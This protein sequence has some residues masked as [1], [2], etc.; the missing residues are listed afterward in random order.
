MKQASVFLNIIVIFILGVYLFTGCSMGRSISLQT[1]L[2]PIVLAD[3]NIKPGAQKVTPPS[4]PKNA[5]EPTP[6]GHTGWVRTWGSEVN[7]ADEFVND[8]AL[9]DFGNILVAGYCDESVDFSGGTATQRQAVTSK[10]ERDG[11]VS[12]WTNSGEFKWARRIGGASEDIIHGAAA[13][14]E[15]NIY[16][17]GTFRGTMDIIIS[18]GGKQTFESKGQSDV[19]LVK[20]DKDGRLLWVRTWGEAALDQGLAVAVDDSDNVYVC[21]VF[22]GTVDFDPGPG[23]ANSHDNGDRDA[24]LLKLGSNGGYQWVRTWGGSGFDSAKSVACGSEGSVYVIGDCGSPTVDFSAGQLP[25]GYMKTSNGDF[26]AFITKFNTDGGFQW[27]Q[28]F[29]GTEEDRGEGVAVCPQSGCAYIAGYFKGSI[30]VPAGQRSKS[31]TLHSQGNTDGFL[32]K[33]DSNGNFMW[34]RASGGEHPDMC[35]GV[36]VDGY[37]NVLTTGRFWGTVNFGSPGVPDEKSTH[38]VFDCFLV[39]LN[40]DGKKQWVRTW[41]GKD[42]DVGK[43]VEGDPIG[44]V[45]VGGIFRGGVNFS[46]VGFNARASQGDVDM[47]LVTYPPDGNW[48]E[49][50]NMKVTPKFKPL[51]Q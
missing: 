21:G 22:L 49:P 42:E 14:S 38:G 19:F 6:W 24:F 25:N 44:G 39:K 11:F 36:A 10:G 1:H 45:Y 51:T 33:Y 8:I 28:T 15:G 31:F 4:T 50:L 18:P 9:D 41:G 16:A 46:P 12:K 17:T 34:V 32:C 35:Y 30:D 47:F 40:T 3:I 27:A 43:C 13:D 23:V 20:M 5:I 7:W 2:K 29:G 48:G 37:G 26:D